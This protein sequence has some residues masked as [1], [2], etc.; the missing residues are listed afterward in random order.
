MQIEI[1]RT[2]SSRTFKN[3]E[4]MIFF[5][6]LFY[7]RQ[8]KVVMSE[9]L[10]YERFNNIGFKD[11][12]RY[13]GKQPQFININPEL[14]Y[15]YIAC[16]ECV[17]DG[18]LTPHFH[19]RMTYDI[20]NMT[21]HIGKGGHRKGHLVNCRW[22]QN[23]TNNRSPAKRGRPKKKPRSDSDNEEDKQPLKKQRTEPIVTIRFPVVPAISSITI[24][25]SD[26]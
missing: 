8:Y 7:S 11:K 26:A 18:T 15:G 5:L 25:C 20:G 14:H 23:D 12:C 6:Q 21:Y 4:K 17:T 1:F 13:C 16:Q 10:F 24:D 2:H 3:D 19:T 22:C 9:F